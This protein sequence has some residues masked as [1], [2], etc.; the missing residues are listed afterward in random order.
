MRFDTGRRAFV[1]RCTANCPARTQPRPTQPRPSR[2]TNQLVPYRSIAGVALGMTRKQVLPI[3]GECRSPCSM[4]NHRVDKRETADCLKYGWGF[5]PLKATFAEQA[6]FDSTVEY[7]PN[8]PYLPNGGDF[9][10]V[11]FLRG[12][13]VSMEWYWTRRATPAWPGQKLFFHGIAMNGEIRS[14]IRRVREVLPRKSVRCLSP[15]LR[16]SSAGCVAQRLGPGRMSYKACLAPP[17][18]D[19]TCF[20][21]PVPKVFL[22][23]VEQRQGSRRGEPGRPLRI[24]SITVTQCNS[25]PAW[26]RPPARPERGVWEPCAPDFLTYQ[27]RWSRFPD[28][29][30]W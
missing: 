5:R 13:V 6:C 18:P 30:E 24:N 1:A 22:A 28:F 26:V 15:R 16:S 17:R 27:R 23:I 10:T 11:A 29:R 2:L 7:Y 19:G 14:V 25:R 4:D 3:L 20:F 21:G 8:G 12:R 9:L